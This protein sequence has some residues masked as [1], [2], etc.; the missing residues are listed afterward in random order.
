MAV[1]LPVRRWPHPVHPA[2]GVDRPHS[3]V[4]PGRHVADAHRRVPGPHEPDFVDVRHPAV[5]VF[6]VP[7]AVH[8]RGVE[9]AGALFDLHRG[10]DADLHHHSAAAVAVLHDN[11]RVLG[12]LR[13]VVVL[14]PAALRPAAERGVAGAGPG[15]VRRGLDGEFR[16]QDRHDSRVDPAVR[17]HLGRAHPDHDRG[18]DAGDVHEGRPES[19]RAEAARD[20]EA[21]QGE[22]DPLDDAAEGGRPAAQGERLRRQRDEL[23]SVPTAACDAVRS[24]ESVPTLS[25][26][27]HGQREH[28]VCGHRGIHQDVIHKNRRTTGRNPER[29]VRAIRRPLSHER[30]RKDL[31]A[32]GLLLLRVRM[33][34]TP[35]RPCHLLCGD[36]PRDDPVDS[37]V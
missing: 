26:E 18:P 1:L 33:S 30:V 22:D 25:H 13:G 28:P 17:A 14:L 31:N 12:V 37:G 24:E 2:H 19:A 11:D 32:R 9:S 3:G 20:G 10:R 8:G 15:P 35:A 5:S 27:Q 23:R 36:G 16:V 21:T 4:W 29:P 7:V 6:V 34:G